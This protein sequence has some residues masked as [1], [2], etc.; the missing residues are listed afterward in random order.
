MVLT[1]LV[2]FGPSGVDLAFL[3][4]VLSGVTV[5]RG[6]GIKSVYL[7]TEFVIYLF[8]I[9]FCDFQRPIGALYNGV[10]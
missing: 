2:L 5:L 10:L 6:S 7:L 8:F 3:Q 4:V 9:Y 1:P